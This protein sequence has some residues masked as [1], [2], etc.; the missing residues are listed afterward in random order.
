M[1]FGKDKHFL[2][3][4]IMACAA[5]R[6]AGAIMEGACRMIVRS[7]NSLMPD[8]I[9]TILWRVQILSSIMQV[10]AIVLMFWFSLRKIR[11]Y[12]SLIDEEEHDELGRLQEETLGKG[13][14]AL[15]VESILQLLQI[16]A[17]I[18][19]GAEGIY[20]ISSIIYRRF[21]LEL[22]IYSLIGEQ[23]D[24]FTSLYTVSHGFKYL[25]MLT[26]ILL[27]VVMTGIFLKDKYLSISAVVVEVAFLLS[28]GLFQMQRIN[29]MGR[30]IGIVWSSVIFH[31]TETVGLIAL[32][33]Y[34]AK[35]YKGL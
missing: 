15:S 33:L 2:S 19:I 8:M 12:R 3:Y 30:D 1:Y 16:W 5:I 9:D 27:G 32:S 20:C 31:L 23:Y 14:S 6:L 35:H 25:E 24:S 22:M 18:L 21:T 11:Y 4:T 34:L 13:L 7:N 17:V 29:L 10:T 28:L 26:A